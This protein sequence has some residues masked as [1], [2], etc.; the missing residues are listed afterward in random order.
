[1]SEPTTVE[2]L[3]DRLIG[4]LVGLSNAINGNDHLI[5]ARNGRLTCAALASGLPD[6][7]PDIEEL[8]ALREQLQREKYRIVPNCAECANRCGRT[9]D[10]DL[11][12]LHNAGIDS[13]ALRT[14]LL[15]S[16]R[17]LAAYT[18]TH[19]EDLDPMPICAYLFKALFTIGM[20]DWSNALLLPVLAEGA[21]H[22]PDGCLLVPA[23][24]PDLDHALCLTADSAI[25]VRIADRC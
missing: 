18:L 8:I 20:D 11:E 9:D 7:H 1:M 23:D 17:P 21:A 16:I 6:A 4:A 14:L 5:D 3:Q 13:R 25:T 12:R 15:A 2:R 24:L 10:Y 22:S 19:W